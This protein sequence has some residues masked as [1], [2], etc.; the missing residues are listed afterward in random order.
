MAA[1]RAVVR[2][3]EPGD[4]RR[5][6]AIRR[7]AMDADLASTIA[8]EVLAVLRPIDAQNA[9]FRP[10]KGCRMV[11]P[12]FVRVGDHPSTIMSTESRLI[13]VRRLLA[14]ALPAK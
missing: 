5:H 12:P 11:C 2:R 14:F 4:R 1:L 3:V 7:K 6:G 9:F 13:P 8:E 10:P